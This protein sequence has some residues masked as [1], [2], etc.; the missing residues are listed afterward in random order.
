MK[1]NRVKNIIREKLNSIQFR[2]F[3]ILCISTIFMVFSIVL[4][5]NLVLESFYIYNKINSAK[6]IYEYINNAYISHIEF[7]SDSIKQIE[8]RENVDI[9]I[10]DSEGKE[11]YIGRKDLVNQITK[12]KKT[13]TTL[14]EIYNKNDIVIKK[15]DNQGFDK[16]LLLNGKLQNGY[17]IF[18]KIS[19]APIQESVKI[20][21]QTLIIIGFLT[22]V[23]SACVSSLRSK[24]FTHPIVQLNKITKKVSDLDFSE[25]YRITDADDEIN[26][27]GKN[28]NIMSE[29]LEKTITQLRQYNNELERDIEE[30]SKIDEMRK[31]FISD[32]SHELKTPIALIQGY[33]EGLMENVNSDDES[34][35]FYAEVIMDESNKMDSMVKELLELMKL[36]YSERQFED[37]EFDLRELINEEI[38]RQ[39]VVLQDNK[40]NIEFEAK[41]KINIVSSQKY[42]EQVINNFITNA[43]KN[44]IEKDGEKKIV[45]RT[46]NRKDKVRVYVYNTG[47]KIPKELI[48]KIWDRFYK[49]DSSR[50]RNVEGSG[51]G[52]SLVKAIMNA[53][54]NDFGVNNYDNGVEFY[55]DFNRK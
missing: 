46:E 24:K 51:I 30:K 39:T 50:N 9:Y 35:K 49:I 43:I 28:I 38:R 33:A 4:I 18:I 52:L 12:Y 29:K 2:L 15:V 22:V 26:K 48:E 17:E 21:N 54:G 7:E 34:R 3:T 42:T 32:V 13:N 53:Y 55:C 6:N 8:I 1:Q 11:V 25:K 27:L 19:T 47:N 40:I 5:N 20:S 31:Q 10:E 14:K 36:E 23:I 16:Y 37:E 45:I 44:C 41:K